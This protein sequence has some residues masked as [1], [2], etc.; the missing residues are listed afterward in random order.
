MDMGEILTD[1]RKV[2][3][4]TQKQI[5]EHLGISERSWQN[6]ESGVSDIRAHDFFRVAL[7]CQYDVLKVM[8]NFVN[9]K[10]MK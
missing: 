1:M 4:K 2:S 6:Y 9:N 3:G 7:F 8:T 5:A 10:R